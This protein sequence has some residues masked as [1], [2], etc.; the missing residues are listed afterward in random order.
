M[1]PITVNDLY[2]MCDIEIKCGFGDKVIL[3]SDDDEGNG[4]HTLFY[5]FTTNGFRH[6]S[7]LF[8]DRNNPDDV[9]LL[10]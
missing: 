2:E 8:H 9:V 1:K 4:F 5:G 7:N 10:G 3:I 6:M